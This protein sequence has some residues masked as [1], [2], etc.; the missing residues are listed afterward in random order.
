MNYNLGTSQEWR[1]I[2]VCWMLKRIVGSK[3]SKSTVCAPGFLDVH[4]Y[5][6]K[7]I[8]SQCISFFLYWDMG[9]KVAV[10]AANQIKQGLGWRGLQETVISAVKLGVPMHSLTWIF[11]LQGP[12]TQTCKESMIWRMQASIG[13]REV[14]WLQP[15]WGTPN[16]IS[17]C[18]EGRKLSGWERRDT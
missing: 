17:F 18:Y 15:S 2:S 7:L 8:V 9:P 12:T 10:K 3:A 5:H 16:P 14:G 6:A 11:S 4:L 13:R 1:L